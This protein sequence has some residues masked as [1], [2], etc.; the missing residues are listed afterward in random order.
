MRM[1]LFN[2]ELTRPGQVITGFIVAP[3]EER[4]REV[5]DEHEIA[6]N[7]ETTSVRIERVD[8]ILSEDRQLGLDALLENAPV[9]FASFCEG[10]GWLAHM[11]SVP[12]LRLFR[13]EEVGGPSHFVVAPD[14]DMAAAIYCEVVPLAV[15]DARLFGIHDGLFGLRRDRRR[16][17]SVLLEVGPVGLVDWDDE[18]GW[19]STH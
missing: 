10:L 12:K 2:V 13:I 9:G 8:E 11:T 18:R 4:A 16:N 7:R 17:L 3:G 14:A 6:L 15:D 1:E 5:L 19:L